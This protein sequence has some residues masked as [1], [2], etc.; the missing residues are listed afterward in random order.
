M[1]EERPRPHARLANLSQTVR[2]AKAGA[3]CAKKYEAFGKNI[4]VHIARFAC[5]N[6][7]GGRECPM[8]E[9]HERQMDEGRDVSI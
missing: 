5:R 2:L 4:F 6:I 1:R 9:R 7:Q 8:D 3:A